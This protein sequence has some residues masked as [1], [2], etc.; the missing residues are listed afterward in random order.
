MFNGPQLP[1]E[2]Y[3]SWWQLYL[4]FFMGLLEDREN[5]IIIWISLFFFFYPRI[6]NDA[7]ISVLDPTE[8]Q[9]EHEGVWQWPPSPTHVRERGC[10]HSSSMAGKHRRKRLCGG[11]VTRRQRLQW[12]KNGNSHSTFIIGFCEDYWGNICE[13]HPSKMLTA[14]ETS[15]G[16][17]SQILSFLSLSL[18]LDAA[19][20]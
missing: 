8:G 17:C 7:S 15:G 5:R 11:R 6:W 13:S 18:L 2:I 19:I 9:G 1:R 3:L 12:K 16:A 4:F 14:T 20:Q 10:W